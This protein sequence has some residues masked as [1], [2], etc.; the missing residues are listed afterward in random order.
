MKTTKEQLK[1]LIALAESAGFDIDQ[2]YS[3]VTM[4]SSPGRERVVDEIIAQ[5]LI[6]KLLGDHGFERCLIKGHIAKRKGASKC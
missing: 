2:F 3:K 5:G 6:R 4:M 1:E